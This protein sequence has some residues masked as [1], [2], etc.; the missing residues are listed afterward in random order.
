[1][2]KVTIREIAAALG[3]EALGAADLVLEG[4]AE[5]ASAGPTDLALAM[6]AKYADALAEG[7]AQAAV[8]GDGMD[9]QAMGLKAAII[10]PRP[11]YAMAH[12]TR[13]MD[14]GPDIAP[15]IHP[16]AVIDPGAEI[17]ATAAIGPFVVV[18]AGARIGARA[19]IEA[20]VFIGPGTTIGDDALIQAGVRIGHGVTIGDRAILQMGASIG[21]DGFSFVTPELSQMERGRKSLGRDDAAGPAQSW[22]RIHSLGGVVLGDD[23]EVGC[24][25]TID[26]G[27]IADTVIGDGTKL[28]AQVHV[29]H[30]CKVG[31]DCLL[32]GQVGLA[33]SV[34]LG[35][36]VVL[37]GRV[38][39]SDNIT[40]GNDVVA[41]VAS[42]L[43]SNVPAG[44][45][46]MG[47]PAVRMDAHVE[48]Y[49]ALRRLPRLAR[50]VA[51]LQKA[52]SK[53]GK[54][55]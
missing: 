26:R 5:P 4:V 6:S 14:P 20:H 40:V 13:A 19:R 22:T 47:Y 2:R 23:V 36:R 41:G 34:V 44:R 29:G 10:A 28:D 43:I 31:R 7:R 39:V 55:P 1:M 52:V 33:G 16:T 12:I 48:I 11:R 15:G 3:A 17:G 45:M 37:G 9:W 54:T 51:D 8:I 49:K 21:G 30:N 24:N 53:S 25:S 42:L 18:G 38:G 50:S 32:C 46:M 35:D 27:T